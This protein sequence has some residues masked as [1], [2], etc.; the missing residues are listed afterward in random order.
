ML[1]SK[2]VHKC[3]RHGRSM[4]KIKPYPNS[5]GF[6]T[7]CTANTDRSVFDSAQFKFFFDIMDHESWEKVQRN[8]PHLEK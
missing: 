5:D 1:G 7:S 2:L 4:F 3:N 8:W 6:K